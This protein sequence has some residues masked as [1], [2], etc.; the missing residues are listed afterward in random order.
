MTQTFAES[1]GQCWVL[2]Q[3]SCSQLSFPTPITPGKWE[4]ALH[5]CPGRRH[6]K[7]TVSSLFELGKLKLQQNC[8]MSGT[9]NTL[10]PGWKIFQDTYH[11]RPDHHIWHL[12][13][14]V[15]QQG[16]GC[17]ICHLQGERKYLYSLSISDKAV[18]TC[19][20]MMNSMGRYKPG[21]TQ[22]HFLWHQESINTIMVYKYLPY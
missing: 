21:S 18:S 4:W 12:G 11:E 16:S 3:K 14:L 13:Q 7:I 10:Q 5:P 22:F 15:V 2:G 17:M 1:P 6:K 20:K 19:R 8:L 9:A